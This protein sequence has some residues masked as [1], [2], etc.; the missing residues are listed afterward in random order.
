MESQLAWQYGVSG[1]I[2]GSATLAQLTSVFDDGKNY[3]ERVGR[4]WLRK[5]GY[6]VNMVAYLHGQPI[7][8]GVTSGADA[9]GVP[10]CTRCS[11]R[12][13]QGGTPATSCNVWSILG[14]RT[15]ALSRAGR[16]VFCS[17]RAPLRGSSPSPDVWGQ[18]HVCWPKT[19][20][21]IQ[22]RTSRP[23]PSDADSR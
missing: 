14:N 23:F 3:S 16:S 6:V 11:V 20:L 17:R 13:R 4:E 2:D 9:P 12:S 5:L 18:F 21:R 15:G 7:T 8:L 1:L 10:N 22:K 19:K